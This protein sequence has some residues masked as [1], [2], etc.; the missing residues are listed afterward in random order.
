MEV[1]VEVEEEDEEEVRMIT[2]GCKC[3]KCI[4]MLRESVSKFVCRRQ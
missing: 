2:A 4:E 1:E 3:L